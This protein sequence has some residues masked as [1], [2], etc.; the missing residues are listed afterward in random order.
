[1]RAGPK[2][3]P[4]G[5]QREGSPPWDWP[6]GTESTGR[7]PSRRPARPTAS[8]PSWGPIAPTRA[9]PGPGCSPWTRRGGAEFAA[10]PPAGEPRAVKDPG[11]WRVRW[12]GK[13]GGSRCCRTTRAFWCGWRPRGGRRICSPCRP[14]PP[15][16]PVFRTLRL[17][18][19]L[20]STRKV[21]ASTGCWWPSAATTG[22]PGFLRQPPPRP[23]HGLRTPPAWPIGSEKTPGP[24]ERPRNSPSGPLFGFLSASD[25]FPAS[26]LPGEDPP[27][28][29][30]PGCASGVF[31]AAG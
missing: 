27:R 31:A 14:G 25:F 30:W 21:I 1:M 13:E 23:R 10:S 7:S 5:P 22:F 12:C 17:R 20:S 28:P 9:A 16:P 4:C 26:R 19:W 29:V 18:G 11:A 8:S 6:T 2:K 15:K 24:C 3:W